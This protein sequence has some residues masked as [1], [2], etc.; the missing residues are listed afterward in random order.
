MARAYLCLLLNSLM[1]VSNYSVVYLDPLRPQI[2]TE[3]SDLAT[4][5]LK[6]SIAIERSWRMHPRNFYHEN[7]FQGK[8]STP[9]KF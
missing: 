1:L 2:K 3:K 8:F 5:D 9:R 7:Y 4:R 6:L